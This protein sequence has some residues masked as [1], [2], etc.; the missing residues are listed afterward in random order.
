[1]GLAFWADKTMGVSKRSSIIDLLNTII[2][3]YIK[4]ANMGIYC[5]PVNSWPE[6]V[7]NTGYP[8]TQFQLSLT[9]KAY[10]P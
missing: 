6:S 9:G 2:W 4:N 1:M 3:V 5:I 10:I 7:V 8:A